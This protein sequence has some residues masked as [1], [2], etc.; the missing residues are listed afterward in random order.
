[1]NKLTAGVLA[2]LSLATVNGSALA[3]GVAYTLDPS[4]TYPS[5]E[6]DHMGISLWR[7]KMNKSTGMMTLDKTS[8]DGTIDVKID[9]A[10]I[11]FG[12]QKLN[13]WAKGKDFFQVDKFPQA[14]YKGKLSGFTGQGTARVTGQLTLHGVT[15]PLD[16]AVNSF[17]CIQHPMFKKDYCGADAEATFDREQFGLTAGKDYGFRMDVKL[18]IQVEAIADK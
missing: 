18:R 8:G 14:E 16:L 11:D 6:A 7:G 12:N 1:M 17:R 10:S 2:A 5:F 3:D 9:P 13:E 15:K 4:H